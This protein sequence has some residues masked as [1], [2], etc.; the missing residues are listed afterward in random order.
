M[1]RPARGALRADTR[2]WRKSSHN[3]AVPR[4]GK[5]KSIRARDDHT[6][7][8]LEAVT[9][10]ARI[11]HH[12]L[13]L[14][15]THHSS[16]SWSCPECIESRIIVIGDAAHTTTPHLAS[17]ASIAI[18]DSIVLALDR[19]PKESILRRFDVTVISRY[20]PE[21]ERELPHYLSHP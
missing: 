9:P 21:F 11:F 16:F 17:G 19:E 13:R 1:R 8:G 12:H 6:T 10:V 18:E 20:F 3:S 7:V 4:T 5:P 14:A 2:N 15:K